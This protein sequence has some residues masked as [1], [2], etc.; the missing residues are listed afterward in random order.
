ME[1]NGQKPNVNIAAAVEAAAVVAAA[2]AAVLMGF[3]GF[4]RAAGC[5][6]RQL[7]N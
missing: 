5:C 4:T 6:I 2:A 1:K 7:T 3:S